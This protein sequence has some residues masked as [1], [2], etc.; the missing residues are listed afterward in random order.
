MKIS[1]LSALLVGVGLSMSG[2]QA[3]LTYQIDAIP[4][5]TGSHEI[6]NNSQGTETEDCWVANSFTV[7]A[8][9]T[10][11]TSLSFVIGSALTN[12]Q[13]TVALYTGT[14]LTSPAGLSRIVSSTN[15]TSVTG[16]GESVATVAFGSPVDLPV[17]QIFY[18]ALL[19]RT[20]PGTLF[21]FADDSGNAASPAP[22]GRSFFDVGATQGG[23]YD[24]DVTSR[25]TVLGGSHPVVTQAQSAGN[26][27]IRVNAIPAPAG[28]GLLALGGLVAG[29]RRRA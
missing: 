4:F 2:A 15:T 6:F 17:G 27:A 3:Q 26:A 9:G 13:V 23:T 29:R 24:L 5:A 16:V 18:A 19:I 14:S 20:V 25:A 11:L 12:Q 8:S 7:A 1:V 21:P 10:H 22:L 28:L